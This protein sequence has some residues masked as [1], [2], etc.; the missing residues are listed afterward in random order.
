[1]YKIVRQLRY[2][3]TISKYIVV[4]SIDKVRDLAKIIY[5]EGIYKE[6]SGS[7]QPYRPLKNREI[8]KRVP[9]PG[10]TS[11]TALLKKG[12]T[13]EKIGSTRAGPFEKMGNEKQK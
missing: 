11:K 4:I 9:I 13:I 10:S 1:M 7:P 8:N 6:K 2:R 3:P 12:K 5:K